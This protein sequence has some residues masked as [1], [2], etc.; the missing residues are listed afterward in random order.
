M[1]TL[2]SSGK[3]TTFRAT[4]PNDIPFVIAAER[5]PDNAPYIG[6]WD[7]QRHI[8]AI[9]AED[10]AH[11][12]LEASSQPVGYFILI[13]LQDPNRSVHLQRVVVTQKGNGYGRQIIQW[14][15]QYAF[16]R[17][18]FHRLWFD[19]VK[20]NEKAKTLY[21]SEGFVIEGKMRDGWKTKQGYEDLLL[22]SM[23][24]SDYVSTASRPDG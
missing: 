20:S 23:L 8:D 19:V 15:K 16:E 17:L 7:E 4:T 2:N 10:K 6:Q 11:F 14:V 3:L 9:A 1:D 12:I 22:L 24:D 13:G 18:R 5:H 21:L